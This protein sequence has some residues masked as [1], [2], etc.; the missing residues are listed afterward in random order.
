MLH[1]LLIYSVII[2][3]ESALLPSINILRSL[4]PIKEQI[5]VVVDEKDLLDQA[6]TKWSTDLSIKSYTVL[7]ISDLVVYMKNKL[8]GYKFNVNT[9]KFNLNAAVGFITRHYKSFKYPI[10]YIPNIIQSIVDGSIVIIT[11]KKN[12]SKFVFKDKLLIVDERFGIDYISGKPLY[13]P[14]PSKSLYEVYTTNLNI[15]KPLLLLDLDDTFCGYKDNVY[16]SRNGIYTF[17]E[18]ALHHFDIYIVSLGTQDHITDRLHEFGLMAVFK[19]RIISREIFVDL[20]IKSK[21]M[22]IKKYN[23]FYENLQFKPIHLVVDCLDR[24]YLGNY[25]IID[26][27]IDVYK[28]SPVL[29]SKVVHVVPMDDLPNGNDDI[30]I[31]LMAND[32]SMLLEKLKINNLLNK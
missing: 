27:R 11:T 17:I 10:E 6:L 23:Y 31:D 5:Y 1:L 25:V 19:D 22:D 24:L 15:K 16:Y 32:F 14:I 7:S 13:I 20:Y 4:T 9:L 21:S 12:E 28:Y 29:K 2:I 30:F 8:N 18:A 26:D 3:E